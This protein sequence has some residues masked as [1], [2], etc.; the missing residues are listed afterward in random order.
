MIDN[1]DTVKEDLCLLQEI[2]SLSN[3]PDAIALDF[4]RY[5]DHHLGRFLGCDMV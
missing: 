3:E 4:R 2:E 1:P 5:L